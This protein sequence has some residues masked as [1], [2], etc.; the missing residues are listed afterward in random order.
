MFLKAKRFLASNKYFWK[1]RHLIQKN[2]FKKSY[3]VLPEKHFNKIFNKK[4]I[5]SV[6]DFGCATGDKLEYFASKDAKYIYGID[7]NIEAIQ[8]CKKKFKY[9]KIIKN[10]DVNFSEKK[11]TK[12]LTTNNLKR[13]DLS[14]LDRVCYI[15]DF[16]ELNDIVRTLSKKSK[17]IYI[18]DFFYSKKFFNLRK[19]IH[20]Y[21]HT[22]FDLLLKKFK[23]KKIY[24]GRSPYKKVLNSNTKSAIFKNNGL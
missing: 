19:K 11:F 14:I 13:F 18:D 4:K 5:I 20:G 12:F 22:N 9:G 1:Y 8:A 15:L 6:L 21:Y 10:F 24:Y 17:Y 23:F 3:G 16:K 2:I 7:I